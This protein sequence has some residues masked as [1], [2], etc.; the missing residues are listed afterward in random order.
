MGE[1]VRLE[2]NPDY[3]GPA[4]AGAEGLL[5]VIWIYAYDE[6]DNMIEMTNKIDQ[7]DFFET[8]NEVAVAIGFDPDKV[9][10]EEV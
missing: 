4:K 5:Q 9:E 2:I 7:G 10:I 3:E 6:D 8:V 1:I